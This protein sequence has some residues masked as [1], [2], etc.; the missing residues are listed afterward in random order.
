MIP[1]YSLIYSMQLESRL[2]HTEKLRHLVRE[3]I[4]HSLRPNIW[5]RLSGAQQKKENSET[6]YKVQLLHFSYLFYICCLVPVVKLHACF[7]AT[8]YISNLLVILHY[9]HWYENSVQ[10]MHNVKALYAYSVIVYKLFSILP[11][12]MAFRF[13]LKHWNL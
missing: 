4:P 11:D 1:F 5:M 12:K 8:E 7:R 6:T 13:F 2:P 10:L 9:S 3:G